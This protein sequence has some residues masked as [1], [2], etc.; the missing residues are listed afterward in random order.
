VESVLDTAGDV[1]AW[2]YDHTVVPLVNGLAD[3][4]QAMLEHPE[5]VL[6]LVGGAGMIVLGGAGEAGGG[7]LDVTGIGAVVGVPVNVAA[8]GLIAAGAGVMV[9]S[10]GDLGSNAAHNDN[11]VLSDAKGP[12]ASQP[13]T[14]GSIEGTVDQLP[15]G[16]S[17][18][19]RTVGSDQELGDLYGRLSEGGTPVDVPGYKG[20]W[21][22]LPDGTRVGLRDVSK[23]G[24]RTID[25]RYPDGTTGKVHVS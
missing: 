18:G 11:H 22:E 20:S 21:V 10:A 15:K 23:S 19:V 17:P 6:G 5:D 7:L 24:G 14:Q 13:S 25:I 8:A 1:G 2:T 12:S 9:A 4:G 3:V 16:H